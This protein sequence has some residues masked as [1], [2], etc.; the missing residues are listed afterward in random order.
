MV[1]AGDAL[2]IV[3]RA[4]FPKMSVALMAQARVSELE[5]QGP[6]QVQRDAD[7]PR[8][9]EAL[10]IFEPHGPADFSS[11]ATNRTAQAIAQ[12]PPRGST[13]YTRVMKPWNS[14]M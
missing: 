3:I 2:V 6:C 13:V 5:T 9:C 4:F 8:R 14:V 7:Q 12:A 1:S 11:P 10:G